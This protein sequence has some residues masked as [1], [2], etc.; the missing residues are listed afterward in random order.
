AGYFVQP[1]AGNVAVALTR[2]RLRDD[3]TQILTDVYRNPDKRAYPV[4]SYSYM[5]VP[6]SEADGF[7][8]EL[9]ASLGQFI[10][11]F[12]C[13][14]QQKAEVL[15]YSPLPKNLVQFAF[16]AERLIPGAPAPPPIDKCANPTITGAFS[17]ANAP[18]PPPDADPNVT[19][20]GNGPGGTN[21]P[22]GRV[23]GDGGNGPAAGGTD[24][25]TTVVDG[26]TTDTTV[27]GEDTTVS[28]DTVAAEDG[29]GD[30]SSGTGSAAEATETASPAELAAAT[31]ASKRGQDT[32][33]NVVYVLSAL[34]VM[35]AIFGPPAL[36][37]ALRRRRR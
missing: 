17:T 31:A 9:G 16:D 25:D 37:A 32:V 36:S 1:T 11:Y 35:L 14:G 8:A 29:G 13:T 2:A 6:T 19:P 26:G 20:G 15:G 4:S 23:G 28:S 34:V 5:I 30:A 3:R 18:Q 24:T 7:T 10:L 27:A 33:S 21:L 12:L 22:V